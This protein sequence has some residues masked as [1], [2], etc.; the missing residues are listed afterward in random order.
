VQPRAPMSAKPV[1]C[2]IYVR[3]STEEGLEQDFNSL[4]AQRESAEAYIL[5]QR[6]EHWI[7]LPRRYDDGGF[8]GANTDRPGLQGLLADIDAGLVDCVT[9]YKVDRLSRSLLDF[10]RIMETFDKHGVSFV[11]VTQQFNTTSPMGRLTLNIL[12]SFA[13]FEREIISERTRDKMVAARRRGKWTGGFPALGYDAD[14]LTRKL[15]VNEAEAQQVR[16][17]FA[18]FLQNQSLA[19]TLHEM[20][21]RG[22]KTKGWTTRKSKQRIGSRFDRPALIRILT[23]VL[24]IGE[25]RHA[26]SVYPGEQPAVI[27]REVWNNV[28]NVLN[29]RKRGSTRERQPQ[30]PLL[31]RRLVCA[32]CESQMV[33]GYTT[34]GGRRYRYYQCNTARKQGATTC[35]GQTVAARR[36]EVAVMNALSELMVKD[37]GKA[38]TE[39]SRSPAT[40]NGEPMVTRQQ[41]SRLDD[42]IIEIRYDHRTDGAQIRL[43]QKV[44][45]SEEEIFVTIRKDP[46]GKRYPP[47]SHARLAASLPQIARRM[48]LAIRFEEMLERGVVRNYSDLA[49]SAGVS[50]TRISQILKLRR[51]APTIQERLLFLNPDAK[52]VSEPVLRRI[53]EELDWKQQIDLF[54]ELCDIR[55]VPAESTDMIGRRPSRKGVSQ[56]G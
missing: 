7:A 30:S 41:H 21:R 20:E 23:N 46:S 47:S 4:D 27:D 39:S 35:P 6:H 18:L 32:V 15:V 26:S 8:T 34:K 43:H 44:R 3:K 37:V 45:D 31:E 36:I 55:D 28:N 2:A 49:Q 50:T 53:S 33:H 38:I 14:P 29:K 25:V 5:S 54:N 16:G 48:A 13:Q 51:L 9:V 1:R 42:A 40:T 56:A 19:D 12:L 11:S 52:Y 17:I 10:A 22:W 24:Y